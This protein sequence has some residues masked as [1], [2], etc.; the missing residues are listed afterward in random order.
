MHTI[1][2]RLLEKGVLFLILEKGLEISE[3]ILEKWLSK[4][5]TIQST[6]HKFKGLK[7]ISTNSKSYD[8]EL[9]NQLNQRAV[10]SYLKCICIA[11]LHLKNS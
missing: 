8:P 7:I 2:P 6:P 5:E 10:K 11:N 3:Q 4:H 1:S 9:E